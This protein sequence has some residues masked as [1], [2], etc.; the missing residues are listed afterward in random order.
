VVA[1][2]VQFRDETDGNLIS[3]RVQV[4]AYLSTDAEGD[5][6]APT[7]PSGGV[8]VAGGVGL[9]VPLVTNRVWQ[10]VSD[11]SGQI[12]LAV[13]EA[14]TATWYLVIGNADGTLSVSGALTFAT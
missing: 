13:T 10:L 7:A 9:A 8:A 6:L 5:V 14:G 1:V 4:T 11:A 3:E 2:G 12:D